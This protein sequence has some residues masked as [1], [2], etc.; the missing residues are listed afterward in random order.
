MTDKIIKKRRKDLVA[1]PVAGFT[2]EDATASEAI[3]NRLKSVLDV[4]TDTELASALGLKYSSVSSAKSRGMIPASWVINVSFHYKISADWLIFGNDKDAVTPGEAAKAINAEVDMNPKFVQIPLIDIELKGGAGTFRD[5]MKIKHMVRMDERMVAYKGLPD[6]LVLI[7][8]NGDSMEPSLSNDDLVLVN[9][10]DKSKRPL[11]R[12]IYA[13]SFDKMIYIRRLSPAPGKW[14]FMP[15]NKK[16][17]NIEVD[18]SVPEENRE[19]KM[20]GRVSW[21]LHT[22]EGSNTTEIPNLSPM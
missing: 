18:L 15:D 13:I 17:D 16:A 9:T 7:P 12:R 5:L 10:S 21:W 20:I 19:V 2:Q 14:V 8:V 6:E 22:E 11:D 4:K 1:G 3:L